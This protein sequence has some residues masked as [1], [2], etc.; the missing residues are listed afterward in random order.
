MEILEH[1]GKPAFVLMPYDEYQALVEKLE[2]VEDNRA[3]KEARAAIESGQDELI[4]ESVVNRLLTENPVKVWRE[5][6]DLKQKELSGLAGVK[7]SMLS[8]IEN[9]NKQGS[10]E[11]MKRLARALQVD[12]DDL[13]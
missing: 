8:Q 11:T 6:R 12:L 7:V 3:Y 1:E 5:Y 10:L 4:P 2:D 9:G 13:T